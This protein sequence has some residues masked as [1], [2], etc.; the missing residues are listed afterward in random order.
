MEFFLE[1]SL[2][3]RVYFDR[4]R[5]IYEIWIRID[6]ELNCRPNNV[7]RRSTRTTTNKSDEKISWNFIAECEQYEKLFGKFI[8][9][10]F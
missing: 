6:N 1:K 10:K 2:V 8:E 7:R 9:K 4:F 3:D 5:L